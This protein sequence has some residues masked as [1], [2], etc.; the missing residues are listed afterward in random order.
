MAGEQTVLVTG[1]SGFLGGWC[2]VEL[3][4]QGYRA[5]ATV[6]DLARA[7]EVSAGVGSQV[8][9]GDRLTF[10]A[11]DLTSDTGWAEAVDGCDYVLHVAS[12]FPPSQPKDADEL[13]VPAREGTLR[14]LRAS[15]DA[16]VKRV[17]VTSSVAA[18]RNGAAAESS[19]GRALTEADWS[20]PQ[21]TRLTPYTRSKTIA[22]LAAWDYVRS[23]DAGERLVTVQP[24]AIIGPLL[25]ADRSYSLQAVERMLTGR[26]P[27]V[28]RLGFSFVDVRDVAA[29]EVAAMTAP[30]A[31]GQRLIAAPWFLWLSDVGA[32]LRRELGEQARKV[33]RRRVPDLAVRVMARFDP[34]IRSVVG[35]LGQRTT[36]S[37]ENARRRAGW[38]P[39]P[40]EETIVDCARSLLDG[41][42]P[43]PALAG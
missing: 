3:L 43:S 22:E 25:G 11:A 28:P 31:A 39:R 21:D 15:L 14:V 17:V 2:L 27:G 34:E 40:I 18:V 29:L 9:M 20:D 4:R 10:H 26:M 41:R 5:R 38:T 19:D 12:P 8:D 37:V 30:E 42:A 13:I 16:G 1:G 24:G 7:S 36:Y 35:E 6:R 32:I 33:P 23:R